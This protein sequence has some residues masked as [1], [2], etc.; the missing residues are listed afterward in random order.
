MAGVLASLQ[1][2][3]LSDWQHALREHDLQPEVL[4]GARAP[5]APL[6]WA[7]IQTGTPTSYLLRQWEQTQQN[8][9]DQ[10]SSRETRKADS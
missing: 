9:P 10:T 5:D 7:F 1:G 4:L 3:S 6:P 8:S 2:T